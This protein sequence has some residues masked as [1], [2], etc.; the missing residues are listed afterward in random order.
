MLVCL[1]GQSTILINTL[2]QNKQSLFLENITFLEKKSVTDYV[3]LLV[4]DQSITIN[5]IKSIKTLIL[6]IDIILPCSIY[7]LVSL[8]KEKLFSSPQYQIYNLIFK[9]TACS[10]FNI[11]DELIL[12]LTEKETLLIEYLL[13]KGTSGATET[14]LLNNIWHY[15]TQTQTSTVETH[16]YRLKNK[17]EAIGLTSIITH[18]NKSY[19]INLAFRK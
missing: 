17:L 2:E 5:Y 11:N 14:E 19:F 15:A 8:I 4:T 12:K 10:I 6:G 3:D 1:S 7:D 18:S 13:K 16:I 9:P